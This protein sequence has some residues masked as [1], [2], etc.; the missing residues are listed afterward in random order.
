MANGGARPGAGRKTK[1]EE[2]GLSKLIDDVIG[3][4]G[5][6]EI[7]EKIL[8]QAKGGSFAHQQLL[9]NYM[10]GKPCEKLDLTS[11]GDK[12]EPTIKEI[13]FRRYADDP[14]P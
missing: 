10:Y 3:D 13:V 6:R 12:I 4:V 14:K 1:A 8:Q 7:I 9:M 5:K 2:M 11:K